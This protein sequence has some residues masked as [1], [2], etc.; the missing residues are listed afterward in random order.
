[1]ITFLESLKIL[2]LS[3]NLLKMKRFLGLVV[4]VLLLN[5]CDDGD[6]QFT[7]FNFGNATV[8]GCTTNNLIYKIN[9]KEALIIDIP[10]ESFKNEIG[11]TTV[12]INSS[13]KVIYRLFSGTIAGTSICSLIPPADPVVTDEWNAA[14]GILEITTTAIPSKPD[15]I[16]G[17]VVTEKYSHTIIFK[18][19]VFRK[20]TEEL[21]FSTYTFGNYETIAN[22]LPF[23]FEN[24]ALQSCNNNLLF[25]INI[26][27]A[28]LL[29]IPVTE[30]P[31]TAGTKTI[32]I[33]NTNKL[34]YR[35][36]D[37][38]ITNNF[39]CSAIPPVDIKVTFQSVAENGE[40]NKT[41]MIIIET[42]PFSNGQGFNHKITLKN[43]VFPN[44]EVSPYNLEFGTQTTTN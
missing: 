22:K 34:I 4:L 26:N 36:Y 15:P 41:G 18:D 33:S 2:F 35:K 29:D 31:S 8:N 23:N 28:L 14:G 38:S 27:E 13:N 20:G 1:M 37:A 42:T 32:L 21:I 12:I 16:T 5:G 7:S 44:T 3:S 17:I 30:F 40:T 25:K 9:G 10:K 19:I 6:M 11:T 43:I 24:A 39:I